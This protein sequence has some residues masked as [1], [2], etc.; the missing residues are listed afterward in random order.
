[1]SRLSTWRYPLIMSIRT[2]M[3]GFGLA[4]ALAAQQATQQSSVWANDVSGNRAEGP[5]YSY[6]ETPSGSQRVETAQSINGRMVPIQAA[7]D[8]VV[9]Q[10]SQSKVVERMI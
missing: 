10:D 4:A 6:V 9:S 2:L 8:R 1:M 7:E 5:R 3:A